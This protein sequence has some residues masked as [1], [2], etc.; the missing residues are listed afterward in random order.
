M[1]TIKFSY[2]GL[3]LEVP[4]LGSHQCLVMN[5]QGDIFMF[6]HEPTIS[7]RNASWIPLHGQSYFVSSAPAI[8]PHVDWRSS[9]ALVN[10]LAAETAQDAS[11]VNSVSLQLICSLV[12]HQG[13]DDIERH[14]DQCYELAVKIVHK[15]KSF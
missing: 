5:A 1:N 6:D 9:Y 11:K 10:E 14:I 2:Y 8:L 7:E 3:I 13:L 4:Y 15:Q 12:Q